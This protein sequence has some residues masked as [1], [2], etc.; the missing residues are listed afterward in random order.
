MEIRDFCIRFS[1]RLAKSKKSR[2]T[3]LLCK[4]KHLNMRLGQNLQEANLAAEIERVKLDLRKIAEHK[5]ER[6]D[7]KKSVE[8]GG[9][10]MAKE[11][12]N[13]S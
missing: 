1:K 4:F 11:I 9:T 12:R 7:Y 10:N 5:K 2:E 6:C 8:H 3:N 13:I